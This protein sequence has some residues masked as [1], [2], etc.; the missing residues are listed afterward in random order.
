MDLTSR[1]PTILV[2]FGI[3]V[4]GI[5]SSLAVVVVLA[6]FI[7]VTL[8]RQVVAFVVA[9]PVIGAP[10]ITIPLLAANQRLRKARGALYTQARVD[11]LTGL[12]N[13]RAFFEATVVAFASRRPESAPLAVLMIDIDR[14]KAVNDTYGHEAGDVL[15]R[16]VAAAIA[17]TVAAAGARRSIV[18]RIGGEEF[19]ALVEGLVPTA[20]GRL[21]ETVCRNVRALA[22]VH[23]EA[24]LGATVSVGVALSREGGVDDAVYAAKHAGRDRWAF[25]DGRLPSLRADG[26]PPAARAT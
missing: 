4:A 3:T 14:F 10:A 22:L 9:V 17:D 23:G 25:A 13:R 16:G 8:T 19:A 5:L 20:V 11:E 15:L 7:G 18:A 1:V 24:K 6:P 2:V 12:P 21:A 26:R